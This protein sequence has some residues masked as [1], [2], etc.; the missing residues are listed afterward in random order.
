MEHNR[1]G[2]KAQD[3]IHVSSKIHDFFDH[4]RIGTLLHQCGVRKRHGYSVRSL[5]V[6]IFALPFFG[7]NFFRGIVT[8]EQSIVGKDAAYDLLKG[9]TY[10]WRRLLLMLAA[11]IH[12]IFSRLTD[13]ERE[14]VLIIDDSTYDRSRS[15]KVELLSRVFDHSTGR[16]LRGFRLLTVS[17]SVGVSTLPLDFTLLSSAKAKNRYQESTKQ[18]DKR[19]CAYRRRQEAT[20]KATEHLRP[21]VERILK[22]GIKAR[23]V[24]MDRWLTMPSNIAALRKYL[25]V[26]GMLKK[27]PR[28]TTNMMGIN[29]ILQRS[30]RSCA[31]GRGVPGFWP[32]LSSLSKIRRRQRSCSFAT[33]EKQTGWHFCRPISTCP[34]RMSFESTANAGIS[35][36]CSRWPNST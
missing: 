9:C 28:S 11:R 27:R 26:I 15:K 3:S 31:N 34:M 12:G 4:F 14:D 36:F 16:Y 6:A 21:M 25:D 8:N 5:I 17:W 30:I 35:K 1:I 33:A 24:L 13:D 18:V 10:N 23:Y 20:M 2:S 22:A 7:K 29:G 19:C 32:P